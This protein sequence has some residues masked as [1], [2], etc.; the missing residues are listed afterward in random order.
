MLFI[1]QCGFE[2]FDFL[3]KL[4]D[5]FSKVTI[6]RLNLRKLEVKLL[7]FVF[8]IGTSFFPIVPDFLDLKFYSFFFL[9]ELI[10]QKL[11]LINNLLFIT[12]KVLKPLPKFQFF[13]RELLFKVTSHIMLILEESFSFVLGLMELVR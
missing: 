4:S 6:F 8:E 1:I 12:F 11:E 10:L 2:L 5:L 3:F 9:A 13:L 7:F